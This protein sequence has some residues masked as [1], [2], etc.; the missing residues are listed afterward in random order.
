[1]A[2]SPAFV[3]LARQHDEFA[4]AIEESGVRWA[5]VA[6][7]FRALGITQQNG[8]PMT[9][10]VL[11]HTWWR[12]RRK[13][14]AAITATNRIPAPVKAGPEPL[15]EPKP[16]PAETDPLAAFRARLNSRSGRP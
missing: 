9:V 13:K 7:E 12:V 3:W 15:P 14:E 8:K 16:Q 2:R 10:P 5:V 1:P 4:A 6:A 11:R